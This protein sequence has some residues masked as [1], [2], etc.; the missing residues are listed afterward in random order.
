MALPHASTCL[1]ISKLFSLPL[2]L[3]LASGIIVVLVALAKVTLSSGPFLLQ[4]VV[5]PTERFLVKCQLVG[6]E[7]DVDC[8]QESRDECER[9]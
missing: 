7:N 4:D 3:I 5:A 8:E 1:L 6:Q 2:F 9:M